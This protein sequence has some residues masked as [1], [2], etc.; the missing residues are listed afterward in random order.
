LVLCR[1]RPQFCE[2]GGGE[3]AI[4]GE[5]LLDALRAHV[6][7]A[8]RVDERLLAGHGA[9]H[10]EQWVLLY[11][12][13]WPY[14]LRTQRL[15]TSAFESPSSL[16]RLQNCQISLAF[17]DTVLDIQTRVCLNARST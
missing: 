15:I 12:R 5:C 11:R 1:L 17:P 14:L 10:L 7:E 13:Q 3:V 2:A 4:E 9:E 16:A 6:G 8:G